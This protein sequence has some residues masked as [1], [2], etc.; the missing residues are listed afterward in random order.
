MDRLANPPPASYQSCTKMSAEPLAAGLDPSS[1]GR[2]F[3]PD[4]RE[5]RLARNGIKL[6]GGGAHQSKTMMLAELSALAC[7][8]V[9]RCP[10]ARHSGA[11]R[12]G[13]TVNSR[14]AR[15][16]PAATAI[17]RRRRAD[18]YCSRFAPPLAA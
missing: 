11:Q 9:R 14:A 6:A 7:V 12:F 8:R 17:V 13:E 4:A 15:G 2:W 5:A 10:D 18:S 1:S 16:P 3:G